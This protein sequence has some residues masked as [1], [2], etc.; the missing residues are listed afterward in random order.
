VRKLTKAGLQKKTRG[1]DFRKRYTLNFKLSVLNL[2][3]Q[4]ESEG[5]GMVPDPQATAARKYNISHTLVCKWAQVEK[6]LRDAMK[7]SK[8]HLEKYKHAMKASNSKTARSMCLTKGRV[9]FPECEVELKE[10]FDIKRKVGLR[11]ASR[12]LRLK[13]KCLVKDK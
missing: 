9:A 11:V 13:M 2:H 8:A 10:D 4:L 3:S 12:Y 1:A 5:R 7:S 6:K